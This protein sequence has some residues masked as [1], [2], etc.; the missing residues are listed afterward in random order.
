MTSQLA[1]LVSCDIILQLQRKSQAVTHSS[2]EQCRRYGDARKG[3]APLSTACAP[4]RFGLL[5]ILFLED[6][7]AVRQQ[8]MMEKGIITFKHNLPLTFS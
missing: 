7:V 8:T 6:Q 2:L 5:K 1:I 3:R 4:P